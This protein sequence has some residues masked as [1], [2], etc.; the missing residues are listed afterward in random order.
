MDR[1]VVNALTRKA[2]LE[3]ELSEIETF[4]KLYHRFGGD[5]VS[6]EAVSSSTPPFQTLPTHMA[7][8]KG[9]G[10][11]ERTIRARAYGGKGSPPTMIAD[12]AV[13]V[14][15]DNNKPMEKPELVAAVESRGLTI[16]SGDKS[17]YMHIILSRYAKDRLVRI[18]SKWGTPQ[19]ARSEAQDGDGI[20]D[21]SLDYVAA[22]AAHK[23]LSAEIA[24]HDARYHGEDAPRISD[25]EYDALRR[26]LE[27]I[28]MR[29]PELRA[30]EEPDDPNVL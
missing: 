7:D 2:E 17:N 14:V 8:H 22:K 4:I 10:G 9:V 13:E 15:I 19:M 25:S 16:A 21:H 26:K 6:A 20:F 29:F 23:A 11:V 1:A 27:Y 18:G 24:E 28:E 5:G 12:T 3:R 30:V